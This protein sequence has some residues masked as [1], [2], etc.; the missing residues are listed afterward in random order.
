MGSDKCVQASCLSPR[1][2]PAPARIQPLR[3]SGPFTPRPHSAPGGPRHPRGARGCSFCHGGLVLL[4]LNLHNQSHT[5][6]ALLNLAASIQC[7]I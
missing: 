2:P 6:R 5:R 4:P 1:D 3:C 7:G